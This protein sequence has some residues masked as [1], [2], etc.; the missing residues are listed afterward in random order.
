MPAEIIVVF[1]DGQFSN[2]VVSRLRG[3]GHDAAALAD[4]MKALDALEVSTRVELLVTCLDF[5]KN[6]PNGIALARMA[7]LKRPSIK[8]LFVGSRDLA[9]HAAD[10]G[11]F[12]ASPVS[13]NDVVTEVERLR[14]LDQDTG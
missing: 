1:A 8:F 10:L 14:T 7:G 12:L 3:G 4:S 11:V 2:E 5:G 13:V 9:P 6:K